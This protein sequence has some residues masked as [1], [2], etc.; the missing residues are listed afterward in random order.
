VHAWCAAHLLRDLKGLYESEP[1]EQDWASRMA[2]LLIEA[3]DAAREARADGKKHL[4]LDGD[5]YFT[6]GCYRLR[7][8]PDR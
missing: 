4:D 2:A 8:W 3:R 7:N 5:G 1:R 6:R